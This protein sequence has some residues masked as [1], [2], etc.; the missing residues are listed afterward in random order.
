TV[1]SRVTDSLPTVELCNNSVTLSDTVNDISTTGTGF[2]YTNFMTD[3][4]GGTGTED[5]TG[6]A[7]RT[8]SVD[9]TCTDGS[10]TIGNTANLAGEDSS[11]QV[12][13][14]IDPI[15]GLPIYVDF[16]CCV[17]VDLDA[18]S[19]VDISCSGGSGCKFC[20]A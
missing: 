9:V 3:I 2:S 1:P 4:G 7:T 11:I 17:G 6:N 16:A 20:D 13:I 18:S 12:Q 8:V 5:I 19:V 15:T 10:G 14:G